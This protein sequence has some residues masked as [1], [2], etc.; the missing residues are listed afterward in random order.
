MGV[1]GVARDRDLGAPDLEA[2]AVECAHGAGDLGA[3]REEHIELDDDGGFGD[4]SETG[5]APTEVLVGLEKAS[6]DNPAEEGEHHQA[7]HQ[8]NSYR[9]PT[10]AVAV[11]EVVQVD[12]WRQCNPP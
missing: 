5:R 11:L 6:P 10:G 2:A 1:G 4:V 7:H 8:N 12:V 3:G 9:G